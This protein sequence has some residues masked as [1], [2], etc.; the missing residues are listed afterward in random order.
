MAA[1]LAT[2][3][4]FCFEQNGCYGLQRSFRSYLSTI[5]MAD[6]PSKLIRAC[7]VTHP[8]GLAAAVPG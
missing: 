1:T 2:N 3:P 4:A 5:S 8:G 7:I 6:Q